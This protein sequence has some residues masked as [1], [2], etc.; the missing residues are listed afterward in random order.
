M[1][2]EDP[3]TV[4]RIVYALYAACA[5]VA[6]ADLFIHRHSLLSFEAWPGFYAWYGFFGCVGLVL[7]AKQLRRLLMRDEDYYD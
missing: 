2:L 6:A 1:R 3:K 4:D 5:A 7:A